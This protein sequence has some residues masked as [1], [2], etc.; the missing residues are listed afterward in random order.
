VLADGID[1]GVRQQVE[2]RVTVAVCPDAGGGAVV[3]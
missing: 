3:V 1:G 2:L